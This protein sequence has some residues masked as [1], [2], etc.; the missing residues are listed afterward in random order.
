METERFKLITSK[1]PPYE[2][3]Y[4]LANDPQEMHDVAAQYPAELERLR[5]LLA[6]YDSGK[7]A[8]AAPAAAPAPTVDAATRERLRALGYMK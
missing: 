8:V 3:L 6:A 4:D 7:P 5:G 1:F 2:N